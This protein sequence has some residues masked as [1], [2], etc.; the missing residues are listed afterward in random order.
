VGFIIG[1]FTNE[2]ELKGIRKTFKQ[3]MCS[4]SALFIIHTA[5]SATLVLACHADMTV[6]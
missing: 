6:S 1:G 5:G 4:D 2:S 3:K